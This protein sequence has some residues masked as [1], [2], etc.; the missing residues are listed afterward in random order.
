ML[1]V[2]VQV[3]LTRPIFWSET[4]H[5]PE[6]ESHDK[7]I[8]P[9]LA[10]SNLMKCVYSR[11]KIC[12][13]VIL[14]HPFPSSRVPPHESVC[15]FTLLLLVIGSLIVC[16]QDQDC[17]AS[18]IMGLKVW[19]Y[20]ARQKKISAF[21]LYSPSSCWSQLTWSQWIRIYVRFIV[22]MRQKKAAPSLW[23]Y[24]RHKAIQRHWLGV[25]KRENGVSLSWL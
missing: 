16:K 13:Q 25:G 19:Y 15:I 22:P 9:D 20:S 24:Q 14:K 18:Y 7:L 6:H 8:S 2:L 4:P 10:P 11:K 23:S 17:R 3:V 21:Q 12:G 1:W 5:K